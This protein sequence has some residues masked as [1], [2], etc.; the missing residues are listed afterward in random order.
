MPN[1]TDDLERMGINIKRKTVQTQLPANGNGSTRQTVLPKSYYVRSTGKFTPD[2]EYYKNIQ[3]KK[4]EIKGTAPT[5]IFTKHTRT[6]K[7]QEQ[8]GAAPYWDYELFS[9]SPSDLEQR[10]KDLMSDYKKGKNSG[11][12]VITVRTR[13]DQR[14]VDDF[15]SQQASLEKALTSKAERELRKGQT[16]AY[17][18][19]VLPGAKQYQKQ[20]ATGYKHF[21]KQLTA[22]RPARRVQ[23]QA[24]LGR[25]PPR[26]FWYSN[27]SPQYQQESSFSKET[28]PYR[29]IGRIQSFA[30]NRPF[31]PP[32]VSTNMKIPLFKPRFVRL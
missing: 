13:A 31:R 14:K 20:L 18:S 28:I 25:A 2:E 3:Q 7:G 32:T 26:S 19:A 17:I 16:S 11:Y 21:E 24:P 12:K 1:S 6:Y 15:I 8:K 9:G 5:Y 23:S 27:P 10:R 22:P 30:P 29:P 4:R